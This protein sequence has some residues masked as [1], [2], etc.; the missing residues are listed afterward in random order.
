MELCATSQILG[1]FAWV[2]L[3]HTGIGPETTLVSVRTGS[4]SWVIL[5]TFSNLWVIWQQI[6]VTLMTSRIGNN[7]WFRIRQDVDLDG[8]DLDS[9]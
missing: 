2:T 5:A 7:F 4:R 1:D 8:L 9:G 3:Y 6:V